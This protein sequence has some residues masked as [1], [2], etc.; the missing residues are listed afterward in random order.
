M[1]LDT[2]KEQQQEDQRKKL[3]TQNPLMKCFMPAL[4][5]TVKSGQFPQYI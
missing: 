3:R 5:P 4:S 2:C 1:H